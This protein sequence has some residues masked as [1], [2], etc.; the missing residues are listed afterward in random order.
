MTL[1][2]NINE[3]KTEC[4]HI[5]TFHDP[6][7]AIHKPEQVQDIIDKL[8]YTAVFSKDE[9]L[10]AK[11]RKIIHYL[12]KETETSSSSIRPL[13]DAIGKGLLHGFTVPAMNLRM[14]TYDVARCIFRV[15]KEKNAGAFIIEIAKTESEY[16]NQPPAEFAAVILA[17]AIKENYFYPVFIQ[18]DHC[19]FSNWRWKENKDTELGRVKDWVSLLLD[20]GF[21][22]IDIDGSTLVD[23]SKPSLH[24]Q[25][26]DNAYVTA[27]MTNFIREQ[28]KMLKDV[29]NIKPHEK[30]ET[31]KLWNA[32][33]S[34]IAIGGEIGHIG[35]KNSTAEDFEAFMKQYINKVPRGAGL[36]KV[37]VQTGTSHGG[38]VS[39]DGTVQKMD[40]DFSV[41]QSIGNVAREKYHIAGPV[42]HGASTLP[43]QSFNK[44]VKAKAVEI[45]LSTGFQNL[46]YDKM[47]KE[48]RN[49]MYSWLKKNLKDEWKSGWTED[50]FLYKTR[51]KAW[52]QFKK[53]VWDLSKNDKENII[54]AM[55]KYISDIF[56]QLNIKDTMESVEK[57]CK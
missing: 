48:L 9:T 16:T 4:Q 37:S 51:K 39:P 49:E 29:N 5:F 26:H 27:E 7:L 11:V 44:F 55:E 8:I 36:S 3:L 25:Q 56:D 42:Q 19:Q 15:A 10:K 50:Q 43:L 31:Q 30:H 46:V 24:A 53:Q 38:V 18:G 2:K 34:P 28:E 23:L 21:R 57:Y 45:H 33:A 22:N 1:Y 41:I 14:L 52:G 40:V 32:A 35:E 6:H 54:T 12:A 13:Y 20:A 17:A 47:P